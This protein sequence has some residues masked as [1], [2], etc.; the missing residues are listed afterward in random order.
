MKQMQ[1]L[2]II[3]FYQLYTCFLYSYLIQ[4]VFQSNQSSLQEEDAELVQVQDTLL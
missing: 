3:H 4:N 2:L 1:W